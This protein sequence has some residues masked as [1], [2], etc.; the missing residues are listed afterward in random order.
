MENKSIPAMERCLVKTVMRL[1]EYKEYKDRGLQ[2]IN[3]GYSNA[4]I[5]SHDAEYVYFN[6]NVGS[7]DGHGDNGTLE[8]YRIKRS[9]LLED[10]TSD[11]KMLDVECMDVEVV[12]QEDVTPRDLLIHLRVEQ[13]AIVLPE[14]MRGQQVKR[15][16]NE[17][18]L[19]I[20]KKKRKRVPQ[21]QTKDMEEKMRHAIFMDKI[22]SGKLQ[23]VARYRK[24]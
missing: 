20:L 1:F 22:K 8:H 4:T 18:K 7:K 10:T 2:K 9:V 14:G 5:V 6:L 3:G 17:F 21:I 11:D 16:N 24:N 15:L 13:G 12:V 23:P 19:R